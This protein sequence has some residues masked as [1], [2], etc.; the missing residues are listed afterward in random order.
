MGTITVTSTPVAERDTHTQFRRIRAGAVALILG[1]IALAVVPLLTSGVPTA[2]E[3][4][5]AFAQGA[6][7]LTRSFR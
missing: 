3:H 2:P 5:L 1:G 7:S 4:N 6:N